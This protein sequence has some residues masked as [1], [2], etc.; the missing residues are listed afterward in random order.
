MGSSSSGVLQLGSSGGLQLGTSGLQSGSSSSAIRLGLPTSVQ[1]TSR[2]AIKLTGSAESASTTDNL[3]GIKLPL[4]GQKRSFSHVEDDTDKSKASASNVEPVIGNRSLVGNPIGLPPLN[5]PTV[6]TAKSVTFKLDGD[7]TK[8]DNASNS[9]QALFGIPQ[10]SLA[11]GG[12]VLSSSGF[13]L[14]GSLP[15]TTDSSS[16]KPFA[17]VNLFPQ[18]STKSNI[19]NFAFPKSTSASTL[20][21]T[22]ASTLLNAPLSFNTGLSSTATTSTEPPKLF[23]FT[24]QGLF[25]TPGGQGQQGPPGGLDLKLPTCQEKKEISGNVT[26]NFSGAKSTE[27][28]SQGQQGW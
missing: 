14:V 19:L 21:T 10:P 1:P 23:N 4:L 8:T 3:G 12:G 9:R 11:T 22:S 7:N 24:Q 13:T 6:T 15:A 26:F 2:E 20:A 27:L 5:R 25:T 28:P 18:S 17:N 16:A